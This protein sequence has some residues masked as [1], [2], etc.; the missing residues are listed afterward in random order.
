MLWNGF[1]KGATFFQ[2]GDSTL[3]RKVVQ[4]T[5]YTMT[6]ANGW[7]YLIQQIVNNTNNNNNKLTILNTIHDADH[8]H[9]IAAAPQ[10][11]FCKADY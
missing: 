9:L 2:V 11:Q 7:S 6:P 10:G 1:S 8:H 4:N 5:L 3:K